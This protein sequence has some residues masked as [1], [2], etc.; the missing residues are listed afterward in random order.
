MYRGDI[1]RQEFLPI[2]A[3]LLKY[4]S[5]ES[6]PL[7]LNAKRTSKTRTIK[8]SINSKLFR[9]MFFIFTKTTA[10]KTIGIITIEDTLVKSPTVIKKP[11][12]KLNILTTKATTVELWE[13]T[14]MPVCSTIDFTTEVSR[15]KFIPFQTRIMPNA[16][17]KMES[18]S[19]RLAWVLLVAFVSAI[20]D[21]I[22]RNRKEA[23]LLSY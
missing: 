5:A 18:Q 12:N 4:S 15:I 17:L 1:H 6:G 11:H 9:S 16:I 14:P 8:V 22:K 19:G 23:N 13:N 2:A 10:T 20:T 3:P 21:K 7:P